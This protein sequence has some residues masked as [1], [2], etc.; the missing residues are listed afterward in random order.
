MYCQAVKYGC[1]NAGFLGIRASDLA[2]PNVTLSDDTKYTEVYFISSQGEATKNA[3]GSSVL[4]KVHM[5][6]A[7]D[8]SCL[9]KHASIERKQGCDVRRMRI[10]D[11]EQWTRLHPH[12]G[13]L[14]NAPAAAIT[15]IMRQHAPG[16]LA[17]PSLHT[18]KAAHI[19]SS[20]KQQVFGVGQ[21]PEAVL[22]AL[23]KSQWDAMVARQRL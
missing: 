10:P 16:L 21:P 15:A 19:S 5:A 4:F 8:V 11:A 2:H 9:D 12:S 17:G 6:L 22:S 7:P 3:R 18:V 23:H 1:P 14:F 20:A 13:G